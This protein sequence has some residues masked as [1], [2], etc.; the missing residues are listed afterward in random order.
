MSRRGVAV[1]LALTFAAALSLLAVHAG[2]RPRAV[3]P[4]GVDGVISDGVDG[5]LID[6]AL[7]GLGVP[8]EREERESVREVP[9]EAEALLEERRA[10]GDC[11]VARSGYLDL[12]GGTWGCVLQGNGWSEVCV[13]TERGEGDGCV[14]YTW[15]MRASDVSGLSTE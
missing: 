14:V 3:E 7:E 9:E 12:L 8:H 6:K 11:V 4:E 10:R 5:A 1:A 15:T 2:T 13:I